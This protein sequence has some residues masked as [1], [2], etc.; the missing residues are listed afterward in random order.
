MLDGLSFR[1]EPGESVAISGASGCGK[2]TL[3]K[4]LAGLLSP[5]EGDILI[6]DEPVARIGVE[7]YRAMIGVVM[8]D[9]QLF[10]GSIA[11]NISF[12]FGTPGS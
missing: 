7:R 4:I 6:N 5:T 3:L 1:I 8:Q 10:A 9:D 11:D 12:F 2:T